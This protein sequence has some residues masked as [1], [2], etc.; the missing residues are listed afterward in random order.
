[1]A[2]EAVRAVNSPK[3]TQGRTDG[4]GGRGGKEGG[5]GVSTGSRRGRETT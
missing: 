2:S 1:M 3:A 5:R 4:R